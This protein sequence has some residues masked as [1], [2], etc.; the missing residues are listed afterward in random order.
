MQ[1]LCIITDITLLQDL[2]DASSVMKDQPHLKEHIFA[3]YAL[4]F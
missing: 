4:Q 2:S 1:K 3:G